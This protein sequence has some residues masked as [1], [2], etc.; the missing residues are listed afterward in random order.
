MRCCMI[1]MV[2]IDEVVML[3]VNRRSIMQALYLCLKIVR[4]LCTTIAVQI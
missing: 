3:L 4:L 1:V 2:K